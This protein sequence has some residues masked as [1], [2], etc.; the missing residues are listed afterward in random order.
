[1][2]TPAKHLMTPAQIHYP[3][4]VASLREDFQAFFD[5]CKLLVPCFSAQLPLPV[6]ACQTAISSPASP[7]FLFQLLWTCLNTLYPLTQYSDNIHSRVFKMGRGSWQALRTAA[8]N[9]RTVVKNIS[10]TKVSA[11]NKEMSTATNCIR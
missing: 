2:S 7:R 8:K 3:T 6:L 5:A 4:S 1:M 9:D 10:V 11:S